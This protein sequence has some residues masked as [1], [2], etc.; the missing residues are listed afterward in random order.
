MIT[1]TYQ[2][3]SYKSKLDTIQAKLLNQKPRIYEN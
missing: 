3:D 2:Q 1:I